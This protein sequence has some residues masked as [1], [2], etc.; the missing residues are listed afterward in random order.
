MR[1]QLNNNPMAQVAIVA[2]LLLGG[3]FFLMSSMGGGGESGEEA[4]GPASATAL[5]APAEGTLP[6][7]AP[8]VPSGV[9]AAS[10]PPAPASVLRAWKSGHTTV[11]LFVRDG[12]IDDRM[13]KE[14]TAAVG[15]VPDVAM[16]VVPAAKIAKYAAITEGVGVERV[17]ALVAITPKGLHGGTPT[18]S[19]HYGYQS[20][21]SIIQAV[22]DAGYRGRTLPYHP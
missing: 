21:E 14:A 8:V 12:G 6:A 3:G 19:V 4:E 17:P 13:V 5:T 9:V 22:I 7:P 16:F 18:A 1:E 11:L 10:A 20:P 2:V 15:S